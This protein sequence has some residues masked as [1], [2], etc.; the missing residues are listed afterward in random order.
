M[1]LSQQQISKNYQESFQLTSELLQQEFNSRG[2]DYNE[3]NNENIDL[4][5][6]VIGSDFVV[7]I[8]QNKPFKKS[9]YLDVLLIAINEVKKTL[10]PDVSKKRF[11]SIDD[12]RNKF[13]LE[14]LPEDDEIEAKCPPANS[15]SEISENLSTSSHKYLIETLLPN[16][17]G[18]IN[19]VNRVPCAR[20]EFDS[21][22]INLEKKIH[23]FQQF[24]PEGKINFDNNINPITPLT[25]KQIIDCYLKVY[26][27]IER[28]FPINFLQTNG[29]KRSAILTQFL[30]NEILESDAGNILKQK[31]ELFFIKHKLQNIY[32]LFNY[33]CNRV[34]GNAYPNLIPPWLESRTST[35]YWKN[36]NNR[37]NAV[38]WLIEKQLKLNADKINESAVP[39]TIFAENGL[40][41]LFNKY[42]N[43]VSS[44][45]A[46][47]YPENEPWELGNVPNKYWTKE[48][49]SKAVRWL[50][51]KK[52]WQV[53]ELPA[54]VRL[55]EFNRKTF[56][57]F[58]LATMFEKKFNKNIY[59]AVSAA[60][61]GRFQP[62][63]FGKVSSQYWKSTY[64]IFHA[65]KWIAITEGIKERDIL[66]SIR[67]KKLTLRIF[68]NHSIGQALKR[69][70][71]GKIEKL[72]GALF[73]NEHKIYLEEQKI[74]R[75][76]KNQKSRFSKPGL[77]HVLLYGLFAKEVSRNHKR[78]QRS[79][80][81]ISQRIS[82]GYFE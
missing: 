69:I 37:T 26:L 18:L 72:F 5:Q 60:W 25:N 76:I 12:D 73:W 52:K 70:S 27:G 54:K 8:I 10:F 20:I 48:N 29:K 36:K 57:E 56:S 77:L 40:S 49:S 33:S 55:K 44:A 28:F 13:L 6:S 34:L 7:G 50:V 78:Q 31:D 35:D 4:I 14:N 9:D 46:E 21:Y 3:I 74:L 23:L 75:K 43:S 68:N 17:P 47:A 22:I 80:R 15:L 65:S 38:R 63:E 42:Y 16:N 79:F 2:H 61:P 39:R 58:G 51:S 62:W 59:R 71:N 1:N 30:I 81:R 53:N 45:L 24:F 67:T 19:L 11:F 82:S 66:S 41:Y 32:R 64:N